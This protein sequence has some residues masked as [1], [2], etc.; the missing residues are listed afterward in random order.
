MQDAW[1]RLEK[2]NTPK[3][4]DSPDIQN[5]VAYIR[6]MIANLIIDR[7]RQF[8][9]QARVFTAQEVPETIVSDTPSPFQVL[10]SQ[11]EFAVLQQA[12]R[13]LPDRSRQVFLLYR[14]QGLSMKEVAAQ[15]QISPRTVE[16]HLAFALSHCRKRLRE[17]GR[18][19]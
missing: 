8:S 3:P 19:A 2:L 13:D 17:V 10:A 16:N 11:Q 6:R 12:I 5:P 18:N 14:G 9:A 4:A 7:Q 15:L 1:I